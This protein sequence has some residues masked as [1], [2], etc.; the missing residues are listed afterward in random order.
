MIQIENL[1]IGVWFIF[2]VIIILNAY[3]DSVYYKERAKVNTKTE[4]ILK[5]ATK[6]SY[7]L[8]LFS[9]LLFNVNSYLHFFVYLSGFILLRFA[10][11]DGIY[12]KLIGQDIKYIGDTSWYDILLKKMFSYNTSTFILWTVKCI[13]LI[14]SLAIIQQINN[15]F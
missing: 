2:L 9:L 8:M 7:M 13:S 15:W 3:A 11:F 12:N 4:S 6:I 14:T 5:H 1:E 10:I